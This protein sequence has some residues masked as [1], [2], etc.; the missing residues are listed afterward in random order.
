[1]PSPPREGEILFYAGPDGTARLEV[2]FED[3]SFW[4]TQKRM[5]DLF[6]ADIRTINE[7]LKTI[8]RSGELN[9]EAVIRKFRITAADGKSYLTGHYNLDAIIAVGYRVNSRQ[10]TQFR[11][12]STGVLKQFIVKGFVLDGQ[13]LKQGKAFGQDYFDELL[14]RIREIRASE[15][16]FYLKITDIYQQC[17]IDYDSDAERTQTFFKTVQNKLHWAVSGQTAAELVAGGAD[18]AKPNMG[19]RT[20]K[21]APAGKILKSDVSVAKNYLTE[22]TIKGLQ[23]IVS[24]YLDYAENQ[25]ARHIPMKMKDWTQ[26][27][28]AFLAFNDYQ[29]LTDAG[30]VSHAVAK[31]LAETEYEKFRVVQ[32]R[33]YESDFE[34]EARKLLGKAKPT[35]KTKGDES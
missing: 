31:T 19:L 30:S 5:S 14:E 17:S 18:A 4:L 9:E 26:K 23:R 16:R 28:D 22:D 11:Q 1:M 2:L 15:R 24:M 13:R 29:I 12:W 3:E 32:D 25:A 35:R 20:W 27:L 7:H 8:F 33:A 6:D 34:R 10:A 21:N